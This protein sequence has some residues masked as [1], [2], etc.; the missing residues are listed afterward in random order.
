MNGL[1][2]LVLCIFFGSTLLGFLRGGAK[3]IIGFGGWLRGFVFAFFGA[4]LIAPLLANL[5]VSNMTRW[6]AAFF[7]LFVLER[8]LSYALAVLLTELV[9]AARLD[10]LNK[11]IGL[12]LGM[13]RGTVLILLGTVL[14]L[15]T[16]IP[17]TTLWQ[18]AYFPP[19]TQKLAMKL[20][21]FFAKD[22]PPWFINASSKNEGKEI[23]ND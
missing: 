18:T 6:L 13:I 16:L 22:L 7:I 3:E 21:P 1:D 5:I 14:C 8:L 10:G 11:I 12:L 23:L 2:I 4:S 20:T 17:S 9:K 15:S 19:I